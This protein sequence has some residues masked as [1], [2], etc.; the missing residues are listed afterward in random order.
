M[1]EEMNDKI[2]RMLNSF[3]GMKSAEPKP[4][5]LTRI[6]AALGKKEKQGI[7]YRLAAFIQRPVVAA[8][9]VI[10]LVL[11]NFAILNRNLS[12]ANNSFAKSNFSAGDDFA[13]NVSGMY[14]IENQEP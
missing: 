11:L 6:N 2:N 12:G 5:L 10:I 1:Q 7:W 3:E 14:D 4:F 8:T 13:I 9:A